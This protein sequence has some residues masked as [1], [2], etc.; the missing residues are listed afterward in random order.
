MSGVMIGLIRDNR[1]ETET[2]DDAANAAH[3]VLV[4]AHLQETYSTPQAYI[5]AARIEGFAVTAVCG[6]TWIPDKDPRRVPLCQAC[7]DIYE[8]DPKG[9]GDRDRLPDA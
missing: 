4:P 3:V 7:K 2:T 5:L 8:N 9:H 6:H 1:V